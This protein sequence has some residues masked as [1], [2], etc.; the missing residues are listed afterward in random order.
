MQYELLSAETKSY[1]VEQIQNYLENGWKLHGPTQVV[2]LS[3]TGI[4]FYQAVVHDG[5]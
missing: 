5:N 1:I 3:P 2:K 4:A